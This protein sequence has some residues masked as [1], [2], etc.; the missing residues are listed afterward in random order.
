M[1]LKQFWNQ[2]APFF[3]VEQHTE[4]IDKQL[5]HYV[6]RYL[7]SPE[8]AIRCID[9]KQGQRKS[10]CDEKEEFSES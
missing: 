1:V 5:H 9:K 8:I 3:G 2:L 6:K 10:E 7:T 4:K